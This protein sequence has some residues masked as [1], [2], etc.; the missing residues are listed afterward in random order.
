MITCPDC[1]KEYTR[2]EFSQNAR[3]RWRCGPCAEEHRK[4]W[5]AA[6]RDKRCEAQR[7]WEEKNPEKVRDN[8]RRQALRRKYGITE[9]DYRRMLASQGGVCAVCGLARPRMVVDHDHRTG[10]VRGILC[11]NCNLIIGH[12]GDSSKV[13]AA[14][15]RYTALP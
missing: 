11:H 8:S 4:A 12:S 13:L 2:A 7:R 15:A 3:Y 14:A 5:L 6:T 9:E 10:K 1:G